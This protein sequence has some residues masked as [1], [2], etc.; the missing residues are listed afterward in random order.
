MRRRLLGVVVEKAVND[1]GD[2]STDSLDL[3]KVG[4]PGTLDLA[5]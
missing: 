5:G 3:F 1:L 4:Q 2:V